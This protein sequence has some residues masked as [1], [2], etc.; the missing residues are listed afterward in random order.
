MTKEKYVTAQEVMNDLGIS[1]WRHMSK[2][3]VVAFASNMYRLEP[4]VAKAAISQFPKF[5]EFGNEIIGALKDFLNTTCESSDKAT[6]KAYEQNSKILENLNH[7]LNK[8][9]LLPGERKR[10]IEAMVE[11]SNN[12]A[13][14]QEQH[15]N[16]VVRNLKYIANAAVGLASAAACILSVVY[17]KKK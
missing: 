9:F 14:I 17:I 6:E 4:E 16:T 8:P 3:K 7:R 2:D 10:I 13:K 5:V 12:I 11:I 1:D 15:G